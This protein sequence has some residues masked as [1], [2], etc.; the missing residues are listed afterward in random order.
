MMPV[1][2]HQ[3]D[4]DRLDNLGRKIFEAIKEFARQ[5]YGEQVAGDIVSD[6]VLIALANVTGVIVASLG[7]D[8]R[9]R[10]ARSA[11][12]HLGDVLRHAVENPTTNRG[13][14]Q[15]FH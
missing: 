15:H 9:E 14:E 5:H 13:T 4:P 2:T 8:C 3:I 11:Q 10:K 12:E 1:K 7:D 6:E